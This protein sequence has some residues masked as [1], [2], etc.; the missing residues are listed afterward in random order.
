MPA[1][2]PWPTTI[3]TARLLLRPAESTDVKEFTRLW[4]DSEVRRFLGGPVAEDKLPAYQQHFANLPNAFAVTT[5]QDMTVVGSVLIDQASRFDDRREV[6]YGL[7]P[8]H[9][10]RGYAREAV[11]G[12]VEW[13]LGNVPSDNPSVIAVTQEANVR[14]CRLLE[15]IGMRHIDSFVEFDA[16]QAMYSVDRQGLRIVQ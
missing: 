6:S 16:P 5:R 15:A 2:N 13:A 12:V 10:G 7:L 11:A 8:E 9:W 4:T 14:S 1:T 3:S